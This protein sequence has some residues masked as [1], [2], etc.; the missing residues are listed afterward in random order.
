MQHC[1]LYRNA[2]LLFFEYIVSL[3]KRKLMQA[4]KVH[5]VSSFRHLWCMWMMWLEHIYFYL[6]ILILKGGIIVHHVWLL[7]KEYLNLFPPN[8]R[9]FNCQQYSEFYCMHFSILFTHQI[10]IIWVNNFPL[11]SVRQIFYFFF[12]QQV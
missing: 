12:L 7:L 9:N 2:D 4:T 11:I 6:N 5:L 10:V 1:P 3:N 8:T